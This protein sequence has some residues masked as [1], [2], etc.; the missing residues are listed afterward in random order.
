MTAIVVR[1]R[2]AEGRKNMRVPRHSTASFTYDRN[3]KTF[4][5]EASE[6]THG[7]RTVYFMSHLRANDARSLGFEL[8]SAKTGCVHRFRLDTVDRDEGDVTAWRFF[9]LN[10]RNIKAVIFND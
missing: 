4:I 9:D 10:D 5:A 8:A 7:G 1:Y 2:F 3:T 6:L